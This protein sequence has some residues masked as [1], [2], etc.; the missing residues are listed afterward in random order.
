MQAHHAQYKQDTTSFFGRLLDHD[1]RDQQ[2]GAGTKLD[3]GFQ[4]TCSL[5]SSAYKC[6][7]P[8]DGTLYR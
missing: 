8:A 2:R 5:W 1:D 7:Y 3:T 6:P 4:T